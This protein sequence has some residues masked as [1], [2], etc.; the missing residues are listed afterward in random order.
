MLSI[1]TIV[2]LTACQGEIGPQGP[3]GDKGEQG[4][5]G[6]AGEDGLSSYE[7]YIK[8]NWYRGTEED[9]INDLA[10][11]VLA[12]RPSQ[13]P[14]NLAEDGLSFTYGKYG[15]GLTGLPFILTSKC[16]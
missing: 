5:Q 15:E 12:I 2:G 14:V 10:N 1:L 4:P 3:G 6:P 16:K 13:Y 8:Y 11:G 7:I 9:W